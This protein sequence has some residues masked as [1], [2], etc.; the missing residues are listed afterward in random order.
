MKEDKNK[1]Y[2][3]I[4]YTIEDMVNDSHKE[5]VKAVVSMEKGIND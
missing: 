3:I 2:K 1:D 5:F 4:R